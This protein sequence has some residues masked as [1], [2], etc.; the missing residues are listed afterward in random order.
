MKKILFAT[1]ALVL[2]LMLSG[3][4]SDYVM[5]T[6]DG[7]TIVPSGKPQTDE[8]TGMIT[9]TDESGKVQQINRNEIKDLS[10]F[11]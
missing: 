6:Q 4:S 5:H 3:C 8:D 2:G 9:Y 11:D 7:R 10:E 1:S